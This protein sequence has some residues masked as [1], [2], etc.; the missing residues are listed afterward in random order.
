MARNFFILLVGMCLASNAVWTIHNDIYVHNG[1]KIFVR[2]GSTL[3]ISSAV[4]N[5]AEIILE[6]GC[7]LS[8]NDN[9]KI[10]LRHGISLN[11]PRGVIVNILSGTIEN[12]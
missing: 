7:T 11:A 9:G 3:T 4:L 8:I 10:K 6:P 2:A 1:V 12:L 5:Q